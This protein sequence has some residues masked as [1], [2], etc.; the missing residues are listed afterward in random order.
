MALETIRANGS[1]TVAYI[2]ELSW[3]IDRDVAPVIIL[4]CMTGDTTLEAAGILRPYAP[5]HGVI[6]LVLK[7]LHMVAPHLIHWGHTLL[8]HPFRD[9]GHVAGPCLGVAEQIE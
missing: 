7:H 8:A 4:L 9:V 6:T 1:I 2:A 3:G 5:V